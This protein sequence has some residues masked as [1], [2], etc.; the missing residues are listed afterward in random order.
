MD[1]AGGRLDSINISSK[2]NATKI[3]IP[4]KIQQHFICSISK[5]VNV[6]IYREMKVNV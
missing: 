5:K 3:L 1:A 2:K 4:E 6:T